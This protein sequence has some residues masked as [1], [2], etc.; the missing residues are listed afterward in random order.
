MTDHS[1]GDLTERQRSATDGNSPAS[2][3]A[4]GV[5]GSLDQPVVAPEIRINVPE[6]AGQLGALSDRP[7]ANPIPAASSEGAHRAQIPRHLPAI[8]PPRFP[9]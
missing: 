9:A 7:Y 2:P 5:R 4:S 8:P 1:A 6:N 3:G